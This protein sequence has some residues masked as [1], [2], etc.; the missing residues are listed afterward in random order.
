MGGQ[1][2]REK[3][4][5]LQVQFSRGYEADLEVLLGDQWRAKVAELQSHAATEYAK[6]VAAPGGADDD[7]DGAVLGA[8]V[9]ILWG[10]LIIGGGRALER[11]IAK[12]FGGVT[13]LFAPIKELSPSEHEALKDQFAMIM[14]DLPCDSVSHQAMVQHA[15][16]FM[17]LNN[18]LMRSVQ[19]RPLWHN[20]ILW[21]V[22]VVG[23]LAVLLAMRGSVYE[24]M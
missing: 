2:V 5:K 23:I 1:R 8:A 20:P 7:D 17:E 9:F 13:E 19:T 14:D 24:V 22:V 18:G 6:R 16:T 12:A 4:Q 3:L 11:K 15:T 21:A 10:P